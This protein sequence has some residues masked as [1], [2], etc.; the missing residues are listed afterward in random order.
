LSRKFS[1]TLKDAVAATNECFNLLQDLA[2]FSLKQAKDGNVDY[3]NQLILL[4]LNQSFYHPGHII[5]WFESFG[6][7]KWSNKKGKLVNSDN[8][9]WLIGTAVTT[10]W[11]DQSLNGKYKLSCRQND[12][13]N[14]MQKVITKDNFSDIL[15]SYPKE[16][17]I[18]D[19][20]FGKFGVPADKNRWG[21]Y[22]V[23]VKRR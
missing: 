17:Y 3:A 18:N 15:N 19:S 11:Y 6:R 5:S 7:L 16:N 14:A 21:K 9:R 20:L 4:S 23:R 12:E 2:V 8:G 10:K 22:K 1:E 13:D